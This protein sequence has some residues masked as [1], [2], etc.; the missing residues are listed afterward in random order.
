MFDGVDVVEVF[1]GFDGDFRAFGRV[2]RVGH[3]G[4]S[5]KVK[6]MHDISIILN[7]CR[8]LT[9]VEKHTPFFSLAF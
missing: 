7:V 2:V 8:E 3:G 1:D 5:L 9:C 6:F 4:S